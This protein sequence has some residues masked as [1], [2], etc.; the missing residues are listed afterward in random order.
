MSA[1]PSTGTDRLTNLLGAFVTAV[2]DDMKRALERELGTGA[3]GPAALLALDT[4]PHCSIEF[5]AG[6]LGLSHSGTV[7]LVDRLVCDDLAERGPGADGRTAALRLTGAGRA[8]VRKARAARHQVLRDVLEGLSEAECRVLGRV[9]D[10][11]LRRPPRSR[12]EARHGC[13]FCDH[14]VCRDRDCPIG[15]SVYADPAA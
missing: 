14:T 5:L 11:V 2:G 15:S 9:L 10:R 3:A 8:R 1:T 7:R 12:H 13:R 6:V 4:W